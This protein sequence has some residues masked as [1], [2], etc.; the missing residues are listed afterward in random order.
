MAAKVLP[1]Y[2]MDLIR[3]NNDAIDEPVKKEEGMGPHLGGIWNY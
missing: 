3:K 1:N 2:V